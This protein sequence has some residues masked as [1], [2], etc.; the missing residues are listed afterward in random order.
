MKRNKA[1]AR[2]LRSS[3]RSAGSSRYAEKV[4][5]GRQMYGRGTRSQ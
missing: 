3:R 4:R 5:S 1:K 2:Q